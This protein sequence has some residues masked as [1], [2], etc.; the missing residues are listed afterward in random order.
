MNVMVPIDAYTSDGIYFY[1]PTKNVIVDGQFTKILYTTDSYHMCGAYIH[2]PASRFT[3]VGQSMHTSEKCVSFAQF[4]P[5]TAQMLTLIE[6]DILEK[7]PS[8]S[9]HPQ[10]KMAD[11]IG[12]GRVKLHS[13]TTTISSVLLKI[14]GIWH[15]K[16]QYGVTYKFIP[17]TADY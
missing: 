9:L 3:V 7:F 14:S 8:A 12:G 17:M 10:Y 6:R 11:Q 15:T 13:R 4:D 5:P 16:T 1:D 2:I